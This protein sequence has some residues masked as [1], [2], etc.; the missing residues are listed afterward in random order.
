MHAPSVLW[1]GAQWRHFLTTPAGRGEACSSTRRREARLSCGWTVG[2]TDSHMRRQGSG[3][4]GER[5]LRAAESVLPPSCRVTG[6]PPSLLRLY[7]FS[8]PTFSVA[9]K[10]EAVVKLTSGQA[11]VSSLSEHLFP[12]TGQCGQPR[13]GDRPGGRHGCS[14]RPPHHHR[15]FRGMNVGDVDQSTL[16]RQAGRRRAELPPRLRPD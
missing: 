6:P 3:V 9:G 5:L 1:R 4:Q 15:V 8:P 2:A 12:P 10:S 7:L 11:V 14:A 16:G 13:R